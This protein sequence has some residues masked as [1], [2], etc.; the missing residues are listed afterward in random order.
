MKLGSSRN[1]C[2]SCRQYFNSNSAFELHRHGQHGVDRRCMT[3]DEMTGRGMAVNAA[4]YWVSELFT[5]LPFK[6]EEHES[7]P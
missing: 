5:K 2:G 7:S 3:A 4:G 6:K 1:Q